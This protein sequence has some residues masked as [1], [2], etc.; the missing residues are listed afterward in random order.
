MQIAPL[1][2]DEQFTTFLKDSATQEIVH[3]PRSIIEFPL[4][5]K[6]KWQKDLI[7]ISQKIADIAIQ[8]RKYRVL[9]SLESVNTQDD[10]LK[11]F[12]KETAQ[13][14][15]FSSDLEKL[16]VGKTWKLLKFKLEKENAEDH[17]LLDIEWIKDLHLSLMVGV[18]DPYLNT[19][20]GKFS[21]AP[22]DTVYKGNFHEYPHF[23]NDKEWFDVFQPKLDQYNTLY[24]F[25]KK[26]NMTE[27]NIESLYKLVAW[28]FL[29]II[30]LHPFSDGNGRCC[31]ILAAYILY[32]INPFPCPIYNNIYDLTENNELYIDSIIK[33]QTTG[34][35]QDFTCILIESNWFA[36]QQFHKFIM[37]NS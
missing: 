36:W 35:L 20:P 2:D 33:A 24:C 28:I 3:A 6:T 15:N 5:Q 12:I 18:I 9:K 29:Q 10:M 19:G 31:R 34:N 14:E 4:P 23:Q 17:G 13:G 11:T 30:K 25:L 7:P 16:N 26:L 21:F 27:K 8:V 37:R 1:D 22:R 32:L